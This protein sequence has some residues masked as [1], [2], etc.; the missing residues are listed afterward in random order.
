VRFDTSSDRPITRILVD[1]EG[2]GE[3]GVRMSF[4]G[5]RDGRYAR[6]LA[7]KPAVNGAWQLTVTAW[8]DQGCSG[9][10]TQPATVIVVSG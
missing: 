2:D 3:P 10:T 5:Q 4:D 9:K 7:F 8:D 1:L 6:A